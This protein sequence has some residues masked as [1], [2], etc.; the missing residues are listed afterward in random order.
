MALCSRAKI[1]LP[2]SRGAADLVVGRYARL[3]GSIARA[4]MCE[5][6]VLGALLRGGRRESGTPTSDFW[7][8]IALAPMGEVV[9]RADRA[10]I[11]TCEGHLYMGRRCGL[12]GTYAAPGSFTFI[13]RGMGFIYLKG[14]VFCRVCHPPTGDGQPRIPPNSDIRY[15]LHHRILFFYGFG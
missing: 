15:R 8:T 4:V 7:A 5:V 12:R 2:R 13:P 10:F 6:L 1:A 3:H 14:D 11:R 9:S